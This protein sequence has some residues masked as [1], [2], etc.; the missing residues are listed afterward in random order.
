MGFAERRKYPRVSEAVPCQLTVGGYTL[1]AETRNISCGGALCR[2]SSVVAP[3][4]QMEISFQLPGTIPGVSGRMIRCVG[5][6]VRQEKEKVL[7]AGDASVRFTT[8]IYFS[9]LKQEDRRLIA[10]FVLQSMLSHDRR[11]T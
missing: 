2:L 5:V 7:S 8:A 9:E 10:E 6:V 11:R 1:V 3:M 4:T